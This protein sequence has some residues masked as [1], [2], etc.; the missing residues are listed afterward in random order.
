M[1]ETVR[2]VRTDS[3]AVNRGR[4]QSTAVDGDVLRYIAAV[5]LSGDIGIPAAVVVAVVDL[6]SVVVINAVVV[7]SKTKKKHYSAEF[8][9]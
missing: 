8:S 1:F 4:S 7:G 2:R 3:D 5:R 6:I 9:V